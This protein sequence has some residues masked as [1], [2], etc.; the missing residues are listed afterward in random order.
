MS[1]PLEDVRRLALL[2]RIQLT[3][4][5]AQNYAKSLESILGYVKRLS[6]IDTTGV[7]E[8]ENADVS[9]LRVDEVQARPAG[10]R[11]AIVANFPDKVGDVLTVPA[12]FETPKG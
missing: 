3:D 10:Q 1:L 12:V 11:E 2:A 5:Q 7:P 8:V 4:E 6:E 9:P